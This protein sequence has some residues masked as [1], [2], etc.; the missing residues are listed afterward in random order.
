MAQSILYLL[1][2]YTTIFSPLV[3]LL[4]PS[5]RH[6]WSRVGLLD[7][8]KILPIGKKITAVGLVSLKNGTPEVSACN[9][10]PFFLFGFF[11]CLFSV[12][13]G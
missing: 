2:L 7:E 11:W 4:T 9:D 6:F 13:I 5:S 3:L 12:D 1:Q 10:L 8:E